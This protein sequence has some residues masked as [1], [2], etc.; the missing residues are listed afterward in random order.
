MPAYPGSAGPAG[1]DA[2]VILLYI[3]SYFQEK[4]NVKK[5]FL[6]K[7]RRRNGSS[8]LMKTK[9][10]MLFCIPRLPEGIEET[11]WTRSI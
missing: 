7:H 9:R 11:S 3:L 1:G 4:E 2:A 8:P 5:V 10:G 6:P